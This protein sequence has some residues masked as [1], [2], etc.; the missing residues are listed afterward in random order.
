MLFHTYEES[1]EA[2]SVH[3]GAKGTLS[4]ERV[5]EQ[6][7]KSKFKKQSCASKSCLWGL[8][9]HLLWV[10][11]DPNQAKRCKVKPLKWYNSGA[12]C[13]P[14][15][16]QTFRAILPFLGRNSPPQTA[17]FCLLCQGGRQNI[18]VYRSSYSNKSKLMSKMTRL[19]APLKGPQYF[20]V[21][22]PKSVVNH[23][24]HKQ[25]FSSVF[26]QDLSISDAS[27]KS[28]PFQCR[29]TIHCLDIFSSLI[30]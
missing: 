11:H 10:C 20:L 16:A 18:C 1:R 5:A 22:G 6:P 23:F 30:W 29:G 14:A 21:S 13:L 2:G 9:S 8:S 15:M 12:T 27:H 7:P 19:V 26:S 24:A 25:L 4:G 17:L 28:F 3:M